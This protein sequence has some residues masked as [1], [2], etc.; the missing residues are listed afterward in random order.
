M[1]RSAK[2]G[3]IGQSPTPSIHVTRGLEWEDKER[4]PISEEIMPD[5]TTSQ[6]DLDHQPTTQKVQ[7]GRSTGNLTQGRSLLDGPQ[8]NNGKRFLVRDDLNV[9]QR[10]HRQYLLARLVFP[11]SS[12]TMASKCCRVK[13]LCTRTS[14]LMK[15]NDTSKMKVKWMCFNTRR[16]PLSTYQ[17][18]PLQDML[19][20]HPS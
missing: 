4:K 16:V 13:T 12:G 20:A 6:D 14:T 10:K 9:S 19:T 3:L 11:Q 8:P 7:C 5:T 1:N 2:A 15:G 18:V 17:Q